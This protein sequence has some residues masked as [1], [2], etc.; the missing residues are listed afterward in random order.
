MAKFGTM[1]LTIEAAFT[2]FGPAMI[3][4]NLSIA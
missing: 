1:T 2:S 4:A 3:S